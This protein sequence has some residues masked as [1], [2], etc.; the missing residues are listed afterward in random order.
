M[1][2]HDSGQ[3]SGKSTGR[4]ALATARRMEM[5]REALSST[6]DGA[7]SVKLFDAW[8]ALAACWRSGE[9]DGEERQ[10]ENTSL[11]IAFTELSW[12]LAGR[13]ADAPGGEGRRDLW[14][15]MVGAIM[16]PDAAEA[17]IRQA[18]TLVTRA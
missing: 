11:L 7:V 15:Q 17:L 14:R 12:L 1:T 13:M 10:W 3:G 6:P 5:L 18:E 2:K 8:E 4:V 9:F 16:P